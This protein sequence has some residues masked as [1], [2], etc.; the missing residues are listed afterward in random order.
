VAK[1]NYFQFQKTVVSPRDN[2]GNHLILP[3]A[4]CV[5]CVSFVDTLLF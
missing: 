3:L 5:F 1:N 4:H 2:G